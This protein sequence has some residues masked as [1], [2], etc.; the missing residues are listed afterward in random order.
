MTVYS[1]NERVPV[2]I[3]IV[4]KMSTPVVTPVAVEAEEAAVN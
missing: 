1:D 3:G 2:Q 4:P